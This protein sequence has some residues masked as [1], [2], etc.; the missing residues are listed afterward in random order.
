[1]SPA[2]LSHI[3]P[4]WLLGIY[5]CIPGLLLLWLIDT[6]FFNEQLLPYMGLG[7]GLLPLYLLIFELPHIVASLL[8]LADK[9]Y[10]HFYKKT[11]G[12]GIPLIIVVAICLFYISP[13]TVFVLYIATTT[14]HAIRQQ[15][16]IASMLARA[17]G[18]WFHLWSGAMITG[19]AL[20]WALIITPQLFTADMITFCSVVVFC[21]MGA[22]I[23]TG[24]MY[25]RTAMTQVGRWYIC[26]TTAMIVTAYFFIRVEYMFFA[27]FALRFVHDVTAF[28]FYIVHDSNRNAITFQNSFYKLF[29]KSNVP[30]LILVPGIS[31]S[32]ALLLR[33]SVG[34]TVQAL[35]VLA[36][37]GFIH[38]F[39]EGVIWKRD[40]MHRQYVSVRKV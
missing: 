1:M 17:K 14:Y 7:A 38:Y 13:L 37:L 3:S 12:L 35:A 30:F 26:S 40:S 9:T 16:G 11:I 5:L 32:L 27:F 21:C 29:K 31:I 4:R 2:H 25:G 23:V 18:L 33:S 19:T 15:T 28:T 24:W 20:A 10:I 39:I 34:D 8:T 36:T 22:S 6:V